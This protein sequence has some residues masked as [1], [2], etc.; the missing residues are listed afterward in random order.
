MSITHINSDTLIPIEEHFRV[1]A[2]PGAGKTYWLVNHIK[3]VLHN[4]ERLGKTRKIACITYTNV[5]VETILS[6]L[7]ESAD[8]VEVSTIHGFL[9]RHIIKPYASFI[10]DEYS[11][12]VLEIDGHDDHVVRFGFI[13]QWFDNHPNKHKLKHPYTEKQLLNL[14]NNKQA[15]INWL[16]SLNYQFNVSGNLKINND[17][18]EAFYYNDKKERRYLSKACLDLLETNFDEYK[19]L[20]WQEGT[21]H[22]DDILFFSYQ[23]IQKFPFILQVLRAKFPYFFIDEFQD[24]SPIQTKILEQIGQKETIVGIIGDKAQSIY[25]FQGAEPEQFNSFHLLY[26]EN[27]LISDNR[28]STNQIIDCLDSIRKD[29][30]Q[31]KVENRE[32]EK[33]TIIIADMISALKKAQELSNGEVIYSLTRDN[34]TSNV[35]KRQISSDIPTDNLLESLYAKD[36]NQER[37]RLVM[38]CIK[39]IELSR[40]MQFK[41]AIKELERIFKNKIDKTKRDVLKHIIFLLQ[42]YHSFESEHL[43]ELHSL[44]KKNI[45]PNISDLRKGAIKD[46]YDGHTYQQLAVCVKITED[47]SF[48]RTIHKAKGAEFDNVLLVLKNEKDLQFL[49]NPDLDKSEEHRIYYVAV[50]R[51]K[52]RLFITVPSLKDGSKAKLEG[53]F[54]I[55]V[56]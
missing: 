19:K 21:L 6:R 30:K 52:E 16:S 43:S 45:E 17:R 34:I 32:N 28:R 7:K 11:L 4:S 40:Q 5:A 22:H 20:Y 36:S 53:L 12:N 18:K 25:G 10:A 27:Y 56:E 49:L 23:L 31:N 15:V 42:H 33:P 26:I 9:Y 1:S 44:I 38:A 29:I 14:A 54:N 48:H 39:A 55:I 37:R 3:N 41:E 8:Q 35:M 51:A 24:T 50:S 46:F 2:G 47:A 13:K